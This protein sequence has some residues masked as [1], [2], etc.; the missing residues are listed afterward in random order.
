M[1]YRQKQVLEMLS[2]SRTTLWRLIKAGD[3]PEP[4]RENARVLF[5]TQ[6][7]LDCWLRTQ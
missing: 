7:Q 4:N 1:S 3:F 5:W 2:I 6:E